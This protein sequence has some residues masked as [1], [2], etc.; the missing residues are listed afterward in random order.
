MDAVM[1]LSNWADKIP[2]DKMAA[3]QSELARVDDSTALILATLPLK[4][5]V[6]GIILSVLLGMMGIDRFYKGDILL[7]VL[8]FFLC[9]LTF[10][11][12]WVLDWF[13]VYRGIKEDNFKRIVHALALSPKSRFPPRDFF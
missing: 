7:G 11:I 1:L 8:K 3:L 4:D 6:L 10:G 5:P 9:W 13:L 12:W 2:Q